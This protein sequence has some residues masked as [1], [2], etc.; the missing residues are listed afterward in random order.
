M[1]KY[2]LI[3]IAF[4]GL[5]AT[6]QAQN[7]L[8]SKLITKKDTVH[9]ATSKTYNVTVTGSKTMLTLQTNVTK[10]TGVTLAGYI[11]YYGSV[12]GAT[13]YRYATDT[14]SNGTATYTK[15]F[16]YNPYYSWRVKYT[17]TNTDSTAVEPWIL[18]RK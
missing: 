6:A 14:L 1:R 18:Y 4:T 9:A 3:L 12:D 16:N 11:D 17:Q 10:I 2:L 13:F 15:S 5:F 7:D 8:R